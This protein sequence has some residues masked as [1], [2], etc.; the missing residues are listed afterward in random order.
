M[1]TDLVDVGIYLC[2]PDVLALFSDNWDYQVCAGPAGPCQADMC[3]ALC[4]VICISA[5]KRLPVHRFP[6][7]CGRVRGSQPGA[8]PRR[9]C[10]GI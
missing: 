6:G 4:S 7:M 8:L 2:E 10:G 1:R 9:T 5:R 3:V